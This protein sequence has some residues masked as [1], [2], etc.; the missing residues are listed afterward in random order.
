MRFRSKMGI[1][2]STNGRFLFPHPRYRQIEVAK[3]TDGLCHGLFVAQVAYPVQKVG[4]GRQV[5]ALGVAERW[6]ARIERAE[7]VV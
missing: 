7:G 3:A 5:V 1:R 6:A 4:V 2:L